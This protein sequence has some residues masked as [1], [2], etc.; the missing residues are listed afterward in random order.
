MKKI[1]FF[2]ICILLGKSLA[3]Q[4]TLKQN[5]IWAFGYHAGLDFNNGE[6][7]VTQTAITA[8]L[9]GIVEGS[10][11]VCDDDGRLLFYCYE[12]AIWNRNHELMSGGDSLLAG[13][14][15]PSFAAQGVAIVPIIGY[16]NKYYVFTLQDATP[17]YGGD[18]N[19]GRLFCTVVD[20]GL[21]NGLGGVDVT[22]KCMRVDSALSDRMVIVPGDDCNFWLVLHVNY[23]QLFKAYEITDAGI[24]SN[25]VIS[26]FSST[27]DVISGQLSNLAGVLKV[28]PDR[29]KIASTYQVDL[30]LNGMGIEVYNFNTLNGKL[31]NPVVLNH[32]ASYGACFSPDNS[33]LY[34]VGGDS[35]TQISQVIQYDLGLINTFDIINSKYIVAENGI[36]AGSVSNFSDLKLGPNG[37]I[38]FSRL[39]QFGGYNERFSQLASISNPNL[40]GTAIGYN[41]SILTLIDTLAGAVTR[42]GGYGMP[43]DYWAI[44]KDTVNHS[45]DTVLSTGKSLTF[46]VT[47]A[48]SDYNWNDGSMDSFKTITTAGSYWVTYSDYCSV[49]TDTFHV[50]WPVSVPS[51][52]KDDMSISVFPNP[53]ATAINVHLEGTGTVDGFVTI[54]DALGRQLLEKPVISNETLLSVKTLPNGIYTLKYTQSGKHVQSR[55]LKIVIAR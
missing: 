39:E 34:V 2:A 38:Y 48:Y 15:N 44:L 4:H 7:V 8:M 27:S 1:L 55:K 24:S 6:P 23:G 18:E 54:T 9:D 36:V 29:R 12:D 17:F 10:A 19:A 37:K 3:A 53:T 25:P 35:A 32:N 5:N 22:R 43:N 50:A 46:A 45:I 14:P 51:I 30:T 16:P 13:Y 20:M 52:V 28:S 41:A 40:S 21:N 42:Q 47:G 31:S 26:D 49:R 11:S 33:K